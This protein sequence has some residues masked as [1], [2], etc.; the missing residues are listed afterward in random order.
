MTVTLDN[1]TE[2]ALKTNQR[3][4]GVLMERL[5]LTGTPDVQR[6]DTYHAAVGLFSEVG[7]LVDGL[8]KSI[9]YGKK[10]KVNIAEEIGDCFWYVAILANA[11]GLTVRDFVGR[12]RDFAI[13]AALPIMYG[14]LSADAGYLL[15]NVTQGMF[16]S[17]MVLQDFEQTVLR[18]VARL[19][20]I[21]DAIGVTLI[22]VLEAN[23]RKLQQRY[24][25]G[26]FTPEHANTRNLDAERATLE[27]SL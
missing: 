6:L 4:Y 14:H 26:H 17:G 12:S 16:V 3:D 1:Y 9:F 21:C 5:N 22:Q 18:I 10:D 25:Q 8:K 19:L 11:W 24:S 2:W 20:C 15:N 7:E 13:V 23:A 27:K